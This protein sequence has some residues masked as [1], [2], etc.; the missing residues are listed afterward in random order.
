MN[1]PDGSFCLELIIE[2][3]IKLETEFKFE[4][5]KLDTEL[6]IELETELKFEMMRTLNRKLEIVPES[7]IILQLKVGQL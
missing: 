5:R 7:K 4:L 1:F 3:E 2:L 6:E